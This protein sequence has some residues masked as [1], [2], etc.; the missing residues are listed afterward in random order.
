MYTNGLLRGRLFFGPS[1][2]SSSLRETERDIIEKTRF[3]EAEER[4]EARK[5]KRGRRRRRRRRQRNFYD[6]YYDFYDENAWFL[7]VLFFF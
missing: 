1:K 3:T 7:S 6:F 4:K 2:R 5:K